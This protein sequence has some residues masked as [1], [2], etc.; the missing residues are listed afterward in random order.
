MK[1][2]R[3]MLALLCLSVLT[4][5]ASPVLPLDDSAATLVPGTHPILPQAEAPASLSSQKNAA[6]YF[7]YLD[8]PYLALEIRTVT[9]SPSQPYELTLITE[10]LAGPGAQSADLTPLFPAG[11]RVV[12]TSLNGRTLFVTLSAEIMN[13][14]PDEPA[15]WQND[16]YWQREVPLRR[17]LCMQSLVATITENCNNVDRVQ[18]LLE[19]QNALA[20]SLRLK[21]RYF[22]LQSDSDEL[23]GPL[24]RQEELLLTPQTA[25]DVI[26]SLVVARDWQ[27]LY[28]Y[29]AVR[30]RET[31]LDR[32]DE[33][34]FIAA[35]EALP[36]VVSYTYAGGSV[37]SDATQV[38]FTLSAALSG[39]AANTPAVENRV[40][41]LVHE[42]GLWRITM[43]QLTGWLE[44]S[45]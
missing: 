40:V 41:R 14:Y 26:L 1:R 45:P 18:V 5:C 13:A 37:A 17:A 7:R 8:E 2:L 43:S 9:Q 11:T 36:A 31:G 33:P 42:N 28:H 12:S 34:G 35:M 32:P 22:M 20:G 23:T 27:R 29:V 10:L 19:Q 3:L 6:L 21:E 30:D 24:V 16:P 38:T 44:V 4:G 15:S 39:M 25:M